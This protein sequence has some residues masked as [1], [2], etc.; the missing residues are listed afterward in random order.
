MPCLNLL[1]IPAFVWRDRGKP[2]THV[3]TIRDS[4]EVRTKYLPYTDLRGCMYN[5]VS[6]NGMYAV[7]YTDV[8]HRLFNVAYPA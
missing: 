1:T 7:A 5:E 6:S 4:S 2:L 8:P 3:K